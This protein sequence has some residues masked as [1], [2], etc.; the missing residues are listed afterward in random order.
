MMPENQHR[1][2]N[3]ATWNV[4]MRRDT[5]SDHFKDVARYRAVGSSLRPIERE[6][7][8]E[9]AGKSLLHL[10]CNLGSDTLSWARLGARV[11]GVD[12]SDEAIAFATRLAE[13]TGMRERA[14]FIRAD[15]YDLP[16]TLDQRFDIVVATYGALCWA[17]D[18]AGWARVAAHHVAP[19]GILLLV[20]THPLGMAFAVDPTD[21]MGHTLRLS[22]SY[23][24]T[25][26]PQTAY[27]PTGE[28][29]HVWGYGLGEVVTAVAATGLRV[30]SLAEHACSFWRQSSQLVESG[31]GY[32]RWPEPD[33][34]TPMLFSL[35]ATRVSA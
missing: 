26:E 6:A 13:E 17:P 34:D 2:D 15:L 23:H 20:D 14:Q 9:V 18:L 32:W 33:N 27:T 35:R 10:Q 22:H 8:G 16:A 29:V 5:D 7:L 31:D 19:G 12:I 30:E 4:W 28:T 3:R 1:E 11:T 25:E 21:A 24:H